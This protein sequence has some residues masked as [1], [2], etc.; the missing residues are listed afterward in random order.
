MIPFQALLLFAL[1]ALILAITPGPNMVY[2][3]SRTL[4]QGK[5]A[6][7][8]SLLGVMV[9]F[10]FH[11]LLVSFGLTAVLFA[12]PYAYT[13]LKWTGALYLVYL[14]FQAVKP[15]GKN[16][17]D[18]EQTLKI[19]KPSKLFSIGF[20]TNVLNPKVAVFYLSLFPQFI[21][22]MHGSV[23]LQSLTLGTTQLIVSFLN[24][25][26]I[27]LF[28]AKLASFFQ[29]QPFWVKIQKW[30]M[31]SVLLFLAVKMAFSKGR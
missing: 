23:L 9:G 21:K 15:N 5:K 31:G 1:A 26:L 8:I 12:I 19:D 14:A 3:I 2:L 24:N 30:F 20:L 11:I 27:I 29:K 18:V 17:F 4:S 10:L 28:A 16:I 13:I 22:P 25:L 6:G 7:L